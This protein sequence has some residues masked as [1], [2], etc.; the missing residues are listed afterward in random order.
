MRPTVDT[1]AFGGGPIT[2]GSQ[3]DTLYSYDNESTA[4][5]LQRLAVDASGLSGRNFR[6]GRHPGIQRQNY[7]ARDTIFA[8]DGSMVDGTQMLL[9]GTYTLPSPGFGQA[10]VVDDATSTVVFAE[11]GELYAYDRDTFLPINSVS[12]PSSNAGSRHQ[13]RLPGVR[14]VR[15]RFREDFHCVGRSKHFCEWVRVR[16]L[17]PMMIELI[18][19][20]EEEKGQQI[21][22]VA[23]FQE[24]RNSL[25]PE[26]LKNLQ[27]AARDRKNVFAQLMEAV[28]FNSE[29]QISHALYDVGGGIE[30]ICEV[31]PSKNSILFRSIHSSSLIH[32]NACVDE[33][34]N[35]SRKFPSVSPIQARLT[36]KR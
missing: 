34:L 15:L 27:Q 23:A 13:L 10:V 21:A 26:S 3:T 32:W 29:G 36:S 22:N 19:S 1:N 11:F 35:R 24:N 30:G 8:T 20:T 12:I 5:A 17:A 31:V 16:I 18:R 28:K 7:L 4:F 14:C 2:F 6:F 9:L 25:A 33:F